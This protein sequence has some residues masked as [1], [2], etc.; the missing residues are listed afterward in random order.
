MG[1]ENMFILIDGKLVL[2]C[3]FVKMGCLGEW[4]I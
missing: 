2:L 3:N 4:N 1:L